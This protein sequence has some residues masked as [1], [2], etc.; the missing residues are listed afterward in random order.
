MTTTTKPTTITVITIIIHCKYA[1]MYTLYY[2]IFCDQGAIYITCISY[3][4][5]TQ[6]QKKLHKDI[7][8]LNSSSF[9]NFLLPLVESKVHLQNLIHM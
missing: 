7:T 8:L 6:E 4:S 3:Y 9:S 2:Y 5:P 1:C